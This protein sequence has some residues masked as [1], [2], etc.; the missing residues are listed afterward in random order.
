MR[1]REY[2]RKNQGTTG[3]MWRP[4]AKH[5]CH[6]TQVRDLRESSSQHSR[7]DTL[8]EAVFSC[9]GRCVWLSVHIFLQQTQKEARTKSRVALKTTPP[10]AHFFWTFPRAPRAAPAV[11]EQVYKHMNLERTAYIQCPPSCNRV[12]CV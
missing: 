8:V 1:A 7:E 3:R 4:I 12:G 10:A 5:L 6:A 9:G 11:R 2:V